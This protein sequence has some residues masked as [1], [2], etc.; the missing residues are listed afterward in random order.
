[1][2]QPIQHGCVSTLTCEFGHPLVIPAS[3]ATPAYTVVHCPTRRCLVCG[4]D[5]VPTMQVRFGAH[6]A[7]YGNHVSEYC[8]SC[9]DA[10]FRAVFTGYWADREWQVYNTRPSSEGAR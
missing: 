4:R 1:M 2:A 10:A 9:E 6:H 8:A 5:D 3:R 7:Y